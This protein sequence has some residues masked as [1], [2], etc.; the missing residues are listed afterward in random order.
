VVLLLV[1]VLW[2]L[3]IY[4]DTTMLAILGLYSQLNIGLEEGKIA[5]DVG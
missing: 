3:D 2:H 4:T 1:V 5:V